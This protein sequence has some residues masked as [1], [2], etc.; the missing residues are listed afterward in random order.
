MASVSHMTVIQ[1]SGDGNC[2]FT[3]MNSPS[4]LNSSSH[5]LWSIIASPSHAPTAPNVLTHLATNCA[6]NIQ[7]WPNLS[8]L[9]HWINWSLS[10]VTWPDLSQCFSPSSSCSHT[11]FNPCIFHT[12]YCL[13]LL[14]SRYRTVIPHPQFLTLFS[15]PNTGCLFYSLE[16]GL[17]ASFLA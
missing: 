16:E 3:C 13:L 6:I 5:R 7:L 10:Y 15:F 8:L 2:T 11:I 4:L 1:I 17:L 12:T 9:I 14:Q